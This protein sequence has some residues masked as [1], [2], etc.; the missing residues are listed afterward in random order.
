MTHH[1]LDEVESRVSRGRFAGRFAGAVLLAAALVGIFLALR[2]PPSSD[3]VR[4]TDVTFA[5]LSP[6]RPAPELHFRDVVA[7][8]LTLADFRGKVV[9]LNIWATWC[10][11]CRREMP[12]LD[13]LQRDLGGAH[14]QVVALSID[15]GGVPAVRSYFE[16]LGMHALGAYVDSTM[17]AANA[18]D[19]TG[20][21]TTFL[22]DASGREVG[23]HVGPAKWDSPA[24]E[25]FLRS[26]IA[27][28]ARGAGQ[29]GS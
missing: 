23:R 20:T 13:R 11:P 28:S 7:R 16:S 5:R 21:P 8:R 14:F 26:F 22:I 18:L 24:N 1:V 29:P 15:T 10:L 17:A 4:G 6:F 9:L 27:A 12:T 2:R 19:I 25:Q 3:Q